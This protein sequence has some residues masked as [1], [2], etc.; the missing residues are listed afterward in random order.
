MKNTNIKLLLGLLFSLFLIS[1]IS[2]SVSV[3]TPASSAT[4]SASASW[5]ASGT[6]FGNIMNCTIWVGSS[7]L[8]ANT[9]MIAM[10]KTSNSSANALW[11]N[12]AF[13]STQ[14]EDANDYQV[15]AQCTN[16]TNV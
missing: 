15:L 5:N 13:D 9:T 14:F 8:T 1:F 3:L 10:N 11:L 6:A 7:S 16:L 4:V 12:G 2:A